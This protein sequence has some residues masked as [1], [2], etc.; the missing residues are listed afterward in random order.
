MAEFKDFYY[1][2]DVFC[3]CYKLWGN[4][5]TV[6][7]ESYKLPWHLSVDLTHEKV[8]KKIALL[9]PETA[10]FHLKVHS[11]ATRESAFE[12]APTD[13]FFAGSRKIV[14]YDVRPLN[15]DWPTVQK[16]EGVTDFYMV[17]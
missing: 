3:I 5:A 11:V 13:D 14:H 16:K 8:E 4:K 15:D 17:D 6:W 1:Q 12:V 10:E 2:V 9:F 7:G